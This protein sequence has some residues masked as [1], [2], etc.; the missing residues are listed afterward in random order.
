MDKGNIVFVVAQSE[1]SIENTNHQLNHIKR[2]LNVN[3]IVKHNEIVNNVQE[4]IKIFLPHIYIFCVICF[5]RRENVYKI[6]EVLMAI[7][8]RLKTQ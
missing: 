3:N 6:F 5:C 4:K 7:F 2:H 8:N 1:T